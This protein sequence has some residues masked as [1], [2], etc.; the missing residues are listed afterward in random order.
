MEKNKYK[1]GKLAQFMEV[2][3][4]SSP[5]LSLEYLQNHLKRKLS[6]SS[7]NI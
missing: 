5:K 3:E 6:S 4:T 7:Q 2:T 1:M